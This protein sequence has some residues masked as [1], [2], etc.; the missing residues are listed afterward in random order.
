MAS[1]IH[2][3]LERSRLISPDA[4]LELVD[5][6][7][8]AIMQTGARIDRMDVTNF[9]VALKHRA[10]LVLAGPAGCGKAAFVNCLANHLV[11]GNGLRRQVLPGHGW[12]AGMSPGNTLLM[13]MHS[14]LVTEKLLFMIEEALLD[15]NAKQVFVVGL[16][17]I[18]PAEL[19]SFFTE[20]V[21]Q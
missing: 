10:I 6:L 20:V 12:Y 2:A 15:E 7:T 17:H 4:E 11:G 3:P 16:T 5:G 19:L 8:N 13:S 18:S 1:N 21:Y 14:R 9:Y